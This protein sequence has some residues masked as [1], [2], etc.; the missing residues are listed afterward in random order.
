MSAPIFYYGWGPPEGH[1]WKSSEPYYTGI[2][3]TYHQYGCSA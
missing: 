3:E 1:G 2:H